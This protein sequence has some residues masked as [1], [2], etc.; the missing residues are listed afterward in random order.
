MP[1]LANPAAPRQAVTKGAADVCPTNDHAP[2]VDRHAALHA[3]CCAMTRALGVV[4][5]S[6]L[7][8]DLLERHAICCVRGRRVALVER[9]YAPRT[10]QSPAVVN[11]SNA[12]KCRKRI[13]AVVRGGAASLRKSRDLFASRRIRVFSCCSACRRRTIPLSPSCSVCGRDY[14]H[15]D[16]TLVIEPRIHGS[17]LKVS[18]L[19]NLAAHAQ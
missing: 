14:P 3:G 1:V 5:G 19:I 18:N 12:T 8:G 4:R 7:F 16:I 17:N 10:A 9:R 2:F 6:T 15:C 11:T 13:E